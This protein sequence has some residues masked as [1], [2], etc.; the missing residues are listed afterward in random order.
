MPSKQ[1][2]VVLKTLKSNAL[3]IATLAGVLIGIIFG[4]S[5]RTREE[6][7]SQREVMYVK[8]IGSLFLQM[9]KAIIIPL[10][11]PSLIVAVGSLD[12][13]LS[14]KIG[15]RAIAYYMG[16]TICAVILGIILV[17]SIQPGKGAEPETNRVVER[18]ITTE[19][20]LMDLVRNL[21]PPNIVQACTQQ[22]TTQLV[23]KPEYEID[24]KTLPK[25]D[26]AFKTSF[27]DNTNILGLVMFSLVFGVAIASVGEEGKP[28]LKFFEA[29]VSIMMKLTSWIINLAPIGVLFLVAG[30]V[31]EMKNPAQIFASLAWYFATVLIGLAIHSMVVLPVIYGVITRS[32]PFGFI[33]NM[34]NALATAFG[35]ASSSATLP[36]TMDALE[37]KNN[38]DPRISRF[39]LPIGA[40]INMDGTALYEAVAAIFIAQVRGV[41]L[42]AGKVAAISITATCA[43]I[44]A[45]G[46]PQAGLVTMV[47]V[48]QTVGLPSNDVALILAV[49]WLLDRFR[50]AINVLGDS[51]GAGIVYHMSKKE[52]EKM[53]HEAVEDVVS[54]GNEV[55]LTE[56]KN[57]QTNSGYE[58]KL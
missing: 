39:V 42:D 1:G 52:L 41:A 55:A 28:V 3:T 34:G 40:T 22:V 47:M 19:D 51:L 9:L 7:W 4:V 54:N 16:T 38:I 18:N 20:T 44:G 21:F 36:V 53:D 24:N 27:Q 50:T 2:Q 31:I 57:G 30:S 23:Y 10:I 12:L 5:L 14:G 35:T 45:A 48:L 32:L 56:L 43:S 15:G 17:T 8:F 46:I 37:Q 26:W 13:S 11:I 25:H 33:K 49:D 6:D 29:F 58:E